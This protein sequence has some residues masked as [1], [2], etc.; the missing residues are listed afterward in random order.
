MAHFGSRAGR[1]TN[2]ATRVRHAA[3]TGHD[4]ITCNTPWAI[5]LVRKKNETGSS[6][7]AVVP[8]C[9][10]SV[11]GGQPNDDENRVV[12]LAAAVHDG[13]GGTWIHGK[14]RGRNFRGRARVV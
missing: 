10:H 3:R 1:W 7:R 2:A 5:T 14:T 4:A 11:S 12:L 13:H 8:A 6:R 9:G